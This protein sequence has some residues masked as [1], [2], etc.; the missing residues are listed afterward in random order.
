MS[1]NFTCI[2]CNV[3]FADAEIQKNH[4]KTDW[5]RY[6]LKRKISQMPPVT[7]EDFQKRVLE[8]KALQNSNQVELNTT[9]YCNACRKQ[10]QNQKAFDNHENSKKH[11][12]SLKSSK[13]SEEVLIKSER[14]IKERPKHALEIEEEMDVDD[15]EEEWEDED[16]DEFAE[17]EEER[18]PIVEECLFCDHQ[19]DNIVKNM[20]HMSVVHSF[21]IPDM[22]FCTDLPN[23]VVYLA[24]KVKKYFICLF[25]NDDGKA[26]YSLDAVRKH[27]SDKGHCQINHEGIN[28]AEY[29]DFYDYSS[30]Y[31]DHGEDQDI[32]EELDDDLL[33]GNEYQLVLPNGNVIG[34]RSLNRYYKQHLNPNRQLIPKKNKKLTRIMNQYRSIGWK[35]ATSQ[36]LEEKKMRIK[37]A[38]YQMRLGVKANK[39]Q[40]HYRE[41]VMF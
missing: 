26:F 40:H 36:Q 21:F 16:V 6:N 37:Q 31:P 20:E 38:K 9:F 13:T 7:S 34:H 35:P 3:K 8:S 24:E 22:E 41:Q 15:D 5:H 14:K 4:Y 27:M 33:E 10:F 17:D 29:S 30:S 1:S 11:K 23:L 32:D 28:M 39:L 18:N 19:S 25:C 12:E 2:N